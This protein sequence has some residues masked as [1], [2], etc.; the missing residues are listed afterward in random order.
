MGREGWSRRGEEFRDYPF[1]PESDDL[2][3]IRQQ[4]RLDEVWQ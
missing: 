1:Q 4:M 2:I 3:V